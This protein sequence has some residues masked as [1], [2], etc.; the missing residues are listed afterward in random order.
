MNSRYSNIGRR[1]PKLDAE[2]KARGK[3]IYLQDIKLPNM[4]HGKILWS[5]YPHAKIVSI[6]TSEAESLPGVKAVITAVDLPALN[7]GFKKDNPP[8]KRDKVRSLRY[9]VA[10]VAAI[11]EDTAEE[12][13]ELIRVEYEELPAVFDADDALRKDAPIVHE[14]TPDNLVPIKYHYEVGDIEGAKKKSAHIVKD[15]F[16]LHYVTHT[17]LG[18][19]CCVAD[20]DGS[21]NLTMYSPTQVPFLYQ[22]DLADVLGIPGS[23]L[24]V[25]QPTIGGGFGSK[26]DLYPYEIICAHLARV[27]RQPVKITFTR[28]EEFFASPCRQ[29]A[30]VDCETGA[31]VQGKLTYRDAHV[32][33]DNGA[34][35]SWGPTIPYVMMNAFSSLYRVKNVRF[36]T[37]IVYTNNIYTGAFRG[38]GNLQGTFCVESQ[39]DELAAK[40]RMDPL[41]FRLLNCNEPGDTTAQGMKITTCALKECLTKAAEMIGWKE[42]KNHPRGDKIRRGVGL[43][44]YFHVGGG[45]RVYMSDGC[46]AIVKFDDFGK[47]TLVTGATDIGQGSETVLAQITAEE[48]GVR[49]EDV[50]I[51]NSDTHVKPW[52]VGVH[53]SRTTFIAGNAARMAAAKAKKKLLELA[54]KELDTTPADLDINDRLIF[55]TSDRK[56]NIRYDKVLRRAHFTHDGTVIMAEHFYDPPQQRQDS[57]FCGNVSVTY[58]FGTQAAEVEVDTETGKV[59]V[60]DFAVANDVGR[61]INPML[62]EGQFEGGAAQGIGYG[63]YENL[64]VVKGEVKNPTFLDYKIVTAKDMPPVKIEL[65]ETNDPAGPFGAKGIGEAGAIPTA[66]AIANAFFDATGV[67]IRELPLAPERVLKALRD[68]AE[69]ESESPIS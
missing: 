30:I 69:P 7:C 1:E 66:A 37:T 45:A 65:I 38:Y 27:T 42:K 57:N 33:L 48:L 63:I 34:Y 61:A 28:Q 46:G 68:G 55:S 11:D 49:T 22:R 56:K 20:W 36:T 44:S 19:C 3:T 29:P 39:M 35:V 15:R 25:I 32:L 50:V 60:I 14:S 8:L 23:K 21:G 12:A 59:R 54:A 13:L 9:E 43:A 52:D 47:V 5:K 16:K 17:C 41:E 24:R 10:A 31:D 18:T 2:A 67:R 62:A 51:V 26:L 64:Q 4:L 6:D 58:T 40:L 53:A